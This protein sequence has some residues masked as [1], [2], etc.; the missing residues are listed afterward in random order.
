MGIFAFIDGAFADEVRWPGLD[1]A[2]L[3]DEAGIASLLSQ[4]FVP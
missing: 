1:L 2:H 3:T 4:W